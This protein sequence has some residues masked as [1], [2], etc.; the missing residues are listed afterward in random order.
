MDSQQTG[1]R[2][3]PPTLSVSLIG[4]A[5]WQLVYAGIRLAWKADAVFS[6]TVLLTSTGISLACAVMLFAGVRELAA[7]STG[8]ARSSLDV[9]RW[10]VAV[11]L[12]A[13]VV[14][15][16]VEC[17]S[18][19]WRNF[20]WVYVAN[21][22]VSSIA[23][24]VVPLGLGF[25]AIQRTT[26]P[27]VIAVVAAAAAFVSYPLPPVAEAVRELLPRSG[28][29]GI[30]THTVLGAAR[31]ALVLSLVIMIARGA[32]APDRASAA[33]G[34]RV[35]ATSLWLR[36]ITAVTFALFTVV[37]ATGNQRG[38]F[39]M[40]KVVIL[41]QS[42]VTAVSFGML[43]WGALR[44]SRASVPGLSSLTLAIGGSAA[45]WACGVIVTQVPHLYRMFYAAADGRASDTGLAQAFTTAIPIAMTAAAGLVA[46]ALSGVAAQNGNTELSSEVQ[47]KGF[48]FVALMII[49]VAIQTWLVPRNTTSAGTFALL[50][51][52]GAA[53][54]IWAMVMLARVFVKGADALA[55]EPGL[56]PASVVSS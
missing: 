6:P 7:R 44:A 29:T 39:D 38:A 49:A 4:L 23:L 3:V 12:L 18:E 48:G 43:G 25:A 16:L 46:T 13:Y 52:L 9:V 20:R 14:L 10:A 50:S 41:A 53:A 26:L 17:A 54:G 27:R 1:W 40:L 47:R 34:L 5:V 28:L 31:H 45:L 22:W 8:A 19:P 15:L 37:A 30:V 55:S 56:P 33:E 21:D 2:A 42:A 51:V 32:T 36:V 35:A 24:M 11:D